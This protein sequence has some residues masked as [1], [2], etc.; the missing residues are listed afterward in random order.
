V[1]AK[2]LKLAPADDLKREVQAALDPDQADDR[3][4]TGQGRYDGFAY[5]ASEAYFLLAGGDKAGLHPMQL[6][7][8]GK[9]H[10]WLINAEDQVIDMTLGPRETS[11]FPYHRGQHRRFRWTP[12]GISR[13]A[14]NIV[15]R[16]VAAR[17]KGN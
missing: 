16:V 2:K 9:S 11:T 6:K 3:Y 15:S 10:W 13:A 17:K 14:E 7:Y 1:A 4:R 12:A 5:I 8:R